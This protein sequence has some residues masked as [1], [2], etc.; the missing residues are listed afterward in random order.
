[1]RNSTRRTL[2]EYKA[3]VVKIRMDMTSSPSEKDK[4]LV[5]ASDNFDTLLDLELLLSLCNFQS[6]LTI[7]LYFIKF[8]QARNIFI[9]N[10]LQILTYVHKK[11]AKKYID[12]VTSFKCEDFKEYESLLELK[13]RSIYMK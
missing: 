2:K 9:Y 6:L 12:P 1:M 5:V 11:L 7:V 3:F 4:C 13:H 8:A 10:F